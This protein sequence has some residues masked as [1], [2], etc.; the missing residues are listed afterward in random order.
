MQHLGAPHTVGLD[1]L[2]F[3][4]CQPAGL[5]EDLFINGDLANVVQG[6]GQRDMILLLCRE[7]IPAADLQQTVEQQFGDGA[8]VPHMG[9]AF[10][11]AEL[12]D[13]A[14]HPHQNIRIVFAG[15]DLI[16]HHLYQPPLLGV[17]LDDVGHPAVYDA[18]IKGTV[19][20]V[21]RAQLIGPPDRIFGVLAGDHDD[22]DILD[23]VVGIHGPQHLKTVHER[24]IDIQQHQRNVSGFLLQFFHAFLSVLRFQNAVLLPQDL[25][26]HHTVHF[27]VVH[28]QDL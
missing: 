28:Q 8:D 17:Q 9:P 4:R 5:V 12:H 14:Q 11:V 15:A 25:R 7:R 27:G 24:H 3:L 13:V 21:A 18:C 6:R 20:I 19:D 16:R 23:G 22:R 2:K 26:Q 1:Q 10:A